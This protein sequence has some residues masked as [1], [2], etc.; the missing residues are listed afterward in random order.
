[1]NRTPDCL[2]SSLGFKPNQHE[3]LS[4]SRLSSVLFKQPHPHHHKRS[5]TLQIRSYQEEPKSG[6]ISGFLKKV[7]GALPIVGLLSR[8]FSEEGGVGADCLRFPEFVRKVDK[9]LSSEAAQALAELEGRHGK[10]ARKQVV[11]LWCWASAVGAGLVKS[12]EILLSA[13]RLRASFDIVYE[14]EGLDMLMDEAIQKR[15]KSKLPLPDVPLTARVQKAF[16]AICICC[17]NMKTLPQS[18][19]VLLESILAGVFPAVERED[20]SAIVG[21]AVQTESK[22]KIESDSLNSSSI[23]T[24]SP[25]GVQASLS[26]LDS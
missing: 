15:K 20:V 24:E 2:S 11:L 5:R 25:E 17:L 4:L 10:M 16:E 8:L 26:V 1:M 3:T 22:A 6:A 18:D 19:A 12:E 21:R 9:N 14:V 23:V 13:R 7:Q